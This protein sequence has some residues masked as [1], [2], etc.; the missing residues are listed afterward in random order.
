MDDK[1]STNQD[2]VVIP[3]LFMGNVI[4]SNRSRQGILIDAG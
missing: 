4:C 2:G 3:I 1:V